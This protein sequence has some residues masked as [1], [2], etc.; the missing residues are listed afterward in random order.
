MTKLVKK[1][2]AAKRAK[3][4]T[5]TDCRKLAKRI[6]AGAKV[7]ILK[8][9]GRFLISADRPTYPYLFACAEHPSRAVAIR[10]L[11]AALVVLAEGR[12]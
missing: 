7:D 11:H 6:G 4:V 1:R 2:T 3:R 9:D 12:K 5:L 10:A 8:D